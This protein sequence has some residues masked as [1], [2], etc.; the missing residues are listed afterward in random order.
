MNFSKIIKEPLLHFFFIGAA[1]FIVFGIL[2]RDQLRS[3]DEIVVEQVRIAGFSTQFERTWQR[4][5]TQS[6]M[7]G[8]IEAWVREEVMYREGLAM[9]LDRNDAVVR[10]RIEQ[11]MSFLADGFVSDAPLEEDLQGW[12]EE[13]SENYRIPARYTLR[14]VYFD[15]DRNGASSGQTIEAVR[16]ALEADEESVTGDPT[17]LPARLSDTDTVLIA[18]SFGR[19][20]VNALPA[21]PV[22]KWSGPVGSSFGVHFIHIAARE[23]SRLPRLDEVRSKVERDYLTTQSRLANEAFYQALRER[24]TVSIET[25][26]KTAGQ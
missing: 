21:L 19:E 6:E 5:P 24:Y 11:K 4:P 1:L 26:P 8:L 10:R 13:N 22:G 23:E 3:P 2:N 25:D 14:Q 20:F 16:R 18:R 17:M 15:P 12:F 9:G 7:E